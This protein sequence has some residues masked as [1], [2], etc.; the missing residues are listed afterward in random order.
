MGV[1]WVACAS[2]SRPASTASPMRTS[3][4]RCG[5]L[6]GSSFSED[7]FTM[8]I[9]PAR[10]G[11]PLEIG[12]LRPEGEEP[13]VIHAAK[14]R[15]SYYRPERP[16][17]DEDAPHGR[18]DP[19][20]GPPLRE[21]GRRAPPAAEWEPTPDLRAIGEAAEEV[22]SGG[23]TIAGGGRDGPHRRPVVE[24]DH[25]PPSVC[26]G[27]AARKRFGGD[28]TGDDRAAVAL[29]PP[30]QRSLSPGQQPA[31]E[32][33]GR[34]LRRC[35]DGQAVAQTLGPH[36]AALTN[37]HRHRLLGASCPGSSVRRP[38]SAPTPT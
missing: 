23:G 37:P 15:R 4:T 22:R 8:P 2:A 20:R 10:D 34:P 26:P 29:P 18:G 25:D 31:I 13:V 33:G 1:G 17:V 36:R 16:E 38:C 28:E 27:Q 11:T 7:G 5:S 19:G 30:T 35:L 3:S 24:P 6:S 32:A 12:I 21:V 14:V 9:G